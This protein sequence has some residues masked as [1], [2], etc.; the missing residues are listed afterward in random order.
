M[1]QSVLPISHI[2]PSLTA[3]FPGIIHPIDHFIVQTVDHRGLP[4]IPADLLEEGDPILF[5]LSFFAMIIIMI[6]ILIMI[7]IIILILIEFQSISF[8]LILIL[9]LIVILIQFPNM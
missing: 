4:F 8:T 9:I 2:P 3:P 6:L 5:T 1:P 7:M